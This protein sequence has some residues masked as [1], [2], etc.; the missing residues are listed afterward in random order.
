MK[1]R[2]PYNTIQ[3]EQVSQMVKDI[4]IQLGYDTI[5]TDEYYDNEELYGDNI[6]ERFYD[7]YDEQYTLWGMSA[8]QAEQFH[9]GLFGYIGYLMENTQ[10]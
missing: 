5:T 2:Q 10:K 8:Q 4:I 3:D 1:D 7:V 9:T 6:I